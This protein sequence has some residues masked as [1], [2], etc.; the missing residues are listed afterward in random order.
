MQGF[1]GNNQHLDQTE[2]MS[3]VQSL[4]YG[5]HMLLLCGHH[6]QSGCSILNQLQ[7]LNLFQEPSR[8]EHMGIV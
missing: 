3:A 1:E 7:L 6:Q 2:D 4:Q 8:V 5:N